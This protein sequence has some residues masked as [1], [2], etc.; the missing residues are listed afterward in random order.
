MPSADAGT[1]PKARISVEVAAH[2]A[3][4]YFRKIYP[5]IKVFS[6]EEVELTEDERHWLITLG[7]EPGILEKVNAASE[8]LP[9]PKTKYKVFKVDAHTGKVISMKIRSL[10]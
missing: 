6:I 2:A 7:Y 5:Q 8:F 1:Q 3:R 4:D 10:G 9:V